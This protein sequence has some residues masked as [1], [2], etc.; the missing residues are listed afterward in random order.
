MGPVAL[1][2]TFR[3][4]GRSDL[5]QTLES[6]MWSDMSVQEG[7]TLGPVALNLTF[8]SAAERPSLE[9]TSGSK[10]RTEEGLA[11]RPVALGLTFGSP[12]AERNSAS[13]SCAQYP[14]AAELVTVLGVRGE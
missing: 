2:Q 14:Y 1:E 7:S 12:K 5:E 9:Q 4:T 3:S 13:M 6:T 11:G 10:M 8:G